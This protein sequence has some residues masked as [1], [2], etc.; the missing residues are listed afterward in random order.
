MLRI[1]IVSQNQDVQKSLSAKLMD[2]G[3]NLTVEDFADGL[4]DSLALEV[5]DLL[6]L[7]LTSH[8][9]GGLSVCKT[10]R[11]NPAFKETPLLVIADFDAVR[12]VEFAIGVD[13]F[14]FPP[15]KASEIAF[16]IKLA[17]WRANKVDAKDTVKINDLIINLANYQVTVAGRPIEL[18]FKEY[19]LLKFLATH[20]GR[21]YSRETLLDR[22][23]GEEY[24]GGTRT[25]DVHVRRLRAKLPPPTCDMVETVRN[26]GYRFQ[27]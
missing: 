16:R 2:M 12:D 7:D 26:V 21:V 20:R 24:F 5:P 23:W 22:V 17:L 14:I 19:E 3:Y 8:F 11:Q 10:V 27:A 4:L 1:A 25:V 13:D 6:L 18:T 9:S 15:A